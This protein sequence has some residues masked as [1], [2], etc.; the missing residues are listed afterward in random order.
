[1]AGLPCVNYRVASPTPTE[2]GSQ[3]KLLRTVLGRCRTAARVGGIILVLHW[4]CVPLAAEAQ[5]LPAS[6]TSA[7]FVLEEAT[8]AQIHSAILA[9]QVTTVGVV[10]GYLRRILAYNGTCVQQPEGILGRVV[11]TA[12]AGQLNA[13][14]TLNLRPEGRRAWGFDDRKA[15]SMTASVDNDPRMPDALEVAA[16]QDRHLAETGQLV[17]PLHGVVVAV[18]D[19]YDTFDMRSTSGGDAAYANDRPPDDATVVARLRERG[20]IILAKANMSE[21]AFVGG[22]S[23]FG[24]TFCNP[25][26]TERDPGASSSGSGTAVAANLVTCAIAEETVSSIRWPARANS[27]VGLSPSQGLVSRDGMIG[28]GPQDRVGPICR[29][30]EDVAKLLDAFAGYDPEDELT[31]YSLARM[32]DQPYAS[33]AAAEPS[34]DGV[35]I[36]VI[37]EYMDPS[38]LGQSDQESISIVERAIGDLRDLGATL[39]DPGPDGALFRTC[40]R[41]Y[42][43]ELLNRDFTSRYPDLFP[44]GPDGQPVGDHIATLL[45]M[46]ADPSLVPDDFDFR[47]LA[48]GGFEGLGRYKMDRYLRDRGDRSIANNADLIEKGTFYDDANFPDRRQGRVQAGSARALDTGDWLRRRFAVQTMVIQCMQEQDL[49][50]LIMPSGTAPPAKLGAPRTPSASKD[51]SLLGWYGFPV[52]SVPAGFTTEVFDRVRSESGDEPPHLVGPK[53]A[54]L[55]VGLDIAAR[56]FDESMLFRIT[57][58]YEAAT[59]HREVPAD[60]GPLDPRR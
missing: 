50:A 57:S 23:A 27:V 24:G 38:R 26:D 35:R 29:T 40:V 11:P 2:P 54:R 16:A 19:Q 39:V 14:S 58:A 59:H 6:A 13:L 5:G 56:P 49:D 51:G 55:P 28:E 17:G 42:G 32:P 3:L 21:Y 31:V 20:A 30:V 22:R 47:S 46:Q 44:L 43:P 37:R 25:Y 45:D 48:Q 4:V 60:F 52:L 8:I 36:G 9:G 7:D 53:P 1:M 18:K 10:E 34:L 33:F 15:R 12:R 41:R